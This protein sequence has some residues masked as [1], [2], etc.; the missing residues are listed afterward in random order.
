MFSRRIAA[1][2]R[3]TQLLSAWVVLILYAVACAPLVSK[4][5]LQILLINSNHQLKYI[6]TLNNTSI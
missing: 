4:D 5:F 2:H 3:L 6:V 1:S